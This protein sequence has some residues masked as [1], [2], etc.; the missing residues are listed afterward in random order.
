MNKLQTCPSCNGTNME[1]GSLS[2][3]GKI[4]FRPEDAKF[5]KLK[6]ANVDVAANLCLDC[7]YVALTADTEKVKSLLD[8]KEQNIPVHS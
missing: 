2:A 6:T 3:T 7:G 8:R 1:A 4:H 5:F